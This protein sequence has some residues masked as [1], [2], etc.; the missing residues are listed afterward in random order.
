MGELEES[1]TEIAI[2]GIDV[3][4]PGARNVSDFWKN[5]RAG[6]NSLTTFNR[7][8]LEPSD[9][10]P[11]D[12]RS[13]RFIPVAGVID[14]AAQFDAAFFGLSKAEA[15]AMDP[16]HRLFLQS[17]WTAMEDSGHDLTNYAGNVA[18][19]AG[20]ASNTYMLSLL[21]TESR[22]RSYQ[23]LVGNDKDYLAT[24][25]SYKLNL[26]GESVAVQTACSTSL[27]AVHLACQSLLLEQCD[28][29]IA[30]GVSVQARQRTGYMYQED[31]IFSPDGS[32]RAFD[33]AASGT[34]FSNG[35]G[36]V[37]LRRL[38]DA[39][40]DG[41]RIYAV[42]KGTAAN[43]D[44]AAK[45]S[46]LAP[47]V[48]AQAA[49]VAAAMDFAEV[50]AHD[51]GYV[52]A[53]GTATPIGDPIEVEALNEAYR[54]SGG[55]G[56]RCALGSVKTNIGHLGVA[57]GVVGLIKTA[58]VLYHREIPESLGFEQPNPMIDFAGG[59][60]YVPTELV[61]WPDDPSIRC[62]GVSSFGIGGT[63]AHAVLELP[64]ASCACQSE[65]T[66]QIVPVSG[67]DPAALHRNALAHRDALEAVHADELGDYAMTAAVGRRHFRHRLAVI[68]STPRGDGTA[69]RPSERA[70][71]PAG[72]TR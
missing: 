7:D 30:G 20:S 42:I 52:E 53:H 27:V 56:A 19:Y 1:S 2:V 55:S 54:R 32:C 13:E 61:P 72:R 68:G 28:F 40:A 9:F 31:A 62:A 22:L 4:C 25:V 41:D 12:P 45:M 37:V 51:V 70:T 24:R 21:G 15:T 11:M 5:L 10:F 43:N 18:V 60:F 46:Y 36:V 58:L 14:G 34:V 50:T 44:A 17:C 16:Q 69:A 63:N 47:S 49:V 67:V 64:P 65:E 38:A 3:R 59:P 35:L 8:E 29:A 66:V 48:N 6:L 71:T 33:A 57:A 39:L 26:S 23:G